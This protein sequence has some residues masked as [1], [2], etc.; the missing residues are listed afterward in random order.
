MATE[1]ET[2]FIWSWLKTLW[3][4]RRKSEEI[5]KPLD[6]SDTKTRTYKQKCKQI[7]RSDN[8]NS[9]KTLE[10]DQYGQNSSFFFSTTYSWRTINNKAMTWQMLVPACRSINIIILINY[11]HGFYAINIFAFVATLGMLKT[12]EKH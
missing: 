7:K 11:T 10:W 6:N 5:F 9:N 4:R 3:R 2:T 12:F 8:K 1:S